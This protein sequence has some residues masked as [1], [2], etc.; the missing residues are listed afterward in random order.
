MGLLIGPPVVFL[1]RVALMAGFVLLL[2]A[3]LGLGPLQ[4]L[5]AWVV[6]YSLGGCDD[7]VRLVD[8]VP[9]ALFAVGDIP[10]WWLCGFYAAVLAL[11]L[12]RR[13]P[14]SLALAAGG[15]CG[16]G[17]PRPGQSAAPGVGRAALHRPRGGDVAVLPGAGITGRGHAAVRRGGHGRSGRGPAQIAPFLWRRGVRHLD[18]VILSHADLDHFNGLAGLLSAS[19]SA[20]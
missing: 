9:G 17:L 8:G 13:G 18:E 10:A 7:L 15:G 3:A 5:P 16:L 1:E 11:L 4:P 6:R 20:R 2:V 19:P 12:L 14:A